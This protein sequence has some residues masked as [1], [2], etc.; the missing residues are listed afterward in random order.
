MLELG[1]EGLGVLLGG[2]VAVTAAPGGDGVRH[3]ADELADAALALR[4]ADMPAEYLETTTLVAV[5]DQNLGI[6][7]SFCSKTFSPFSFEITALR[8]SHSTV[9]K[10]S[11][12]G[13]V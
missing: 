13:V 1:V 11:T 10:G 12:P 5:C 4:G 8:S 2:E 7:T 6:S 9:S 3:P